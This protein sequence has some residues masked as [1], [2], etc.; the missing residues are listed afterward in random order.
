MSRVGKLPIKY[1]S[2]VNVKIS[3]QEVS[4]KGPKGELSN[5]FNKFVSIKEVDQEIMVSP[6]DNSAGA[7]AMWGTARSII[8]GMVKGVT[9]GYSAE[10]EINGVG[11]RANMQDK[12]LILSLGKS[13][14]TYIE[15]PANISIKVLKQN[16]ILV[17]SICKHSIGQ[18][19]A[20][21]IKERRPEPYKGKGIYKKGQ[22][23]IRKEGKKN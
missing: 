3:G 4:V 7:R 21:L 20:K 12:Y 15:T 23:I 1:S 10:V 5:I 17:E 11:Y 22:Y 13:H 8:A 18:F 2:D 6:I 9:E 16:L 14:N 19:I